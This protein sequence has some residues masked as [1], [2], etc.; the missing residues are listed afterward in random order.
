MKKVVLIIGLLFSF[1][2][3]NAQSGLQ[4][5]LYGKDLSNFKIESLSDGDILK[6]KTYL[7]SSGLTETQAEQMAMQ[8]GLPYTEIAKLKNRIA[9]ISSSNNANSINN[10]N[11]N[12]NNRG[13]DTSNINKPITN[14][15]KLSEEYFGA[16]LF[17]NP[18]IDFSPDLR[19]ATPK[20]YV[21][22]PDDEIA[23]DVYGY[24][25]TNPR[26]TVSPEGN[27]NI[28]NVGYVAV[29]GITI[30]AATRRIKD[31]M[32]RNG[33]ASIGSGQ[34]KLE[35][36]IS[37]IRTIKVT[38]V[39]MARKPGTYTL[40]S[41]S[42]VFNALY[43]CGGP[44]E[45]G[46]F[47]NI[48]VIRGKKVIE[49]L[50]AYDFLMNG[51]QKNDI[52][53]TDEDVIRIPAAQIQVKLM[54]EIMRPGIFE[55]KQNE[56]LDNLINFAQGFSS[57]AYTA[58][59]H[60]VQYTD[61]EKRVVDVIKNNF[62]SYIPQK[63]D[64]ITVGKILDRF[65]N[66]VV[67]DG[68]IF[69]PGEYE[70]TNNLSLKKLIQNADGITED[71]YKQRA[72]LIR[73]NNDFTK[74]V[75][76]FNLNDL[77]AGKQEDI[78][79]QKNDSIAI[80]S[81]K[82]FTESMSISVNGEIKKPGIYEYYKGITLNDIL[83]QTGGFT[84]AASENRIEIARRVKADSSNIL[85]IAEVINVSALSDL[86]ITQKEI[87]LEP[88][89]V[90][91]I[92]KNPGYHNQISVKIEGEVLYPGIY[93]LN[94]KED[95][96]SDILKRAGGVTKQADNRGANIVRINTSYIKNDAVERV[97]KIQ[98]GKDTSTQLITELTKPTVKIGLNLNEI[99][100]NTGNSLENITLLEGDIINIPKQRNVVKI[101]GEV[102]FP[103]EV[104]YKEGADVEYYIGKAGGFTDNAKMKRL[105][106]LNS[107][108]SATK[109]KSL[110][111]I[112]KYP[113]VEPGSEILVPK[114]SDKN[115]NKL[116]TAEWL[117]LASGLA[118]LA[119]VA[120][121]IINVTK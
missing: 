15:A 85:N 106:V 29:S 3:V 83:F 119:S 116:T 18:N 72:L 44:N 100:N 30:E 55:M 91:T 48:E 14:V 87:M 46:S 56:T 108:G 69:R 42:S 39:G 61:K 23:I 76:P 51:Y 52:R 107:N 11:K 89:D 57:K 99:L 86:T 88:W 40:S 105:Y 26:L 9:N 35:V 24:Q 63:G 80:A 101:S 4:D 79:L 97:E 81:I 95:K 53:L 20:N 49:K 75:F 10:K 59:V 114:F 84:S 32:I 113:K 117:A 37:K 22:G 77:F 118:S 7:Q 115:T 62:S 82:D 64:E 71:A 111:G 28:P 41:L 6:Y 50:D 1:A 25:E 120:I 5:F 98:K 38:I 19:I 104:V 33:Y 110:F 8:R 34:T 2:I 102:M 74:Q 103:T 13:V 66:R 112:K 65:N 47:R 121:A 96:V 31:K 21:I 70:L 94:T 90:V 43:A 93:V 45:K 109:T 17:N 68:A 78:L 36:S 92:R 58:S 27:I 67:I 16:E 60:I 54:G 73:T 12:S